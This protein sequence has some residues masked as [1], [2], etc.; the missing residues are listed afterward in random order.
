MKK[1]LVMV[2]LAIVMAIMA[3][4]GDPSGGSS[5]GSDLADPKWDMYFECTARQKAGG[6]GVV[7]AGRRCE[8]LRPE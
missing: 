4:G 6:Y 5:S 7:E 8:A 1:R 3:C 2:L